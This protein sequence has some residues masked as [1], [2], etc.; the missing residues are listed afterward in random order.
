M[1]R[2]VAIIE[3]RMTS[4]RLP[5]KVLLHVCGKPMLE[6]LIERV[7]RIPQVDEVVVATTWNDSDDPVHALAKDI[8]VGCY[9]GSEHDVLGRVLGAAKT[10][11]ADY[12]V[13]ITGDCPL[14]DP[15]LAEQCIDDFFRLQMDYGVVPAANFPSGTAVQ[16]FPVSILA[17]VDREFPDNP[18]AREHVSLPIY[19]QPERY[20]VYRMAAVSE[21]NRPDLRFDL[22]TPEDFEL[23]K[24]IY[25][26]LY[27]DKPD[28]R[29]KDILKLFESRPELALINAEVE[30]KKVSL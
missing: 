2:I 23:I 18:S 30:Q 13:E 14:L 4:S 6:L 29:L 1:S 19:S 22:D 12:I 21:L 10:F 17:E 11:S 27:K 7:N 24:N 25:E 26:A 8:G 16:I 15:G 9:R 5:G 28:F 3:A 20:K